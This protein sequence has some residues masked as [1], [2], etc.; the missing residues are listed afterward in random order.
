MIFI[1]SEGGREGGREEL[2][3]GTISEKSAK[4]ADLSQGKSP[5]CERA[6]K[7]LSMSQKQFPFVGEFLRGLCGLPVIMSTKILDFSTLFPLCPHLELIYI[8]KFT[9][10]PLL[11][12]LFHDPPPMQTYFMDAP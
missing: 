2:V 10:P 3:S 6:S 9:Q 11:C 8:I 5:G 12:T 1:S 7:S 4:T